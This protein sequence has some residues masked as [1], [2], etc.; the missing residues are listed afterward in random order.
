[1]V[2]RHTWVA[3]A[4]GFL[5]PV[6]YLLSIGIGIGGLVGTV[7][8]AG[9]TVSYASFA[10]PG[11]MASSAMNGAVYESTFN[12]YFKI[13]YA[14]TYDA[15]LAT[16]LS[17]ADVATGEVAWALL[18]GAAYAVVFLAVMLIMGLVHSWLAVLA[19]PVA[20]LIGFGFAAV[21]MAATS[22]MRSW[23]DF[24]LVQA[25]IMPLFLFSATFYPLSTYPKGVQYLVQLT[26]LYHGVELLRAT[27][28]GGFGPGNLLNVV[29]LTAMGF[30]GLWVAKRRLGRLLQP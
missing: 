1:M 12:I 7:G 20:V 25:V 2:S 4:S 14:K 6:F 10:A 3:F 18:R 23:Q 30:A 13:K 15:V 22:Y 11:L 5:E 8:N 9:H 26:P 24:D 17:I 16:P 21:G 19:V 28:L 27:T 29:Y